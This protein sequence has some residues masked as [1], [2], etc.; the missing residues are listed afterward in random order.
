EGVP[1]P[2]AGFETRIVP[3]NITLLPKT[4]SQITGGNAWNERIV[5]VKKGE[6]IAS[7]LKEIGA[8]ADEIAAISSALG[9][10]GRANGLK[11]GQK[12][13][14]LVAAA[15]QAARFQP[16]RV[17]VLGDGTV[18]A[19]VALS[20]KGRYVSVDVASMNTLVSDTADD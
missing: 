18:D 1:D 8:T 17:V 10:R 14:I 6:N 7:I 5:T 9:P 3:E 13:R 4:A 2:Y 12:L 11:E 15:D 16:V 19:V 20:D